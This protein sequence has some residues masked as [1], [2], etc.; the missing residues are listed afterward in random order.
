MISAIVIGCIEA[1]L[2][3]KNA[4]QKNLLF[5]LE[6]LYYRPGRK[7]EKANALSRSLCSNPDPPGD[8]EEHVVAAVNSS[9]PLSSSKG[10]DLSLSDLQRCDRT[11]APYFSYLE[12]GI[13]PEEVEARELVLNKSQYT[14]IDDNLYY[15]EKDKTL[16]VIPPLTYRK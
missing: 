8:V 3:T 2:T 6:A 13:L 5:C 1:G 16:K 15:V 4:D 10:R 7:N 9:D 12:D 11:L 14:V